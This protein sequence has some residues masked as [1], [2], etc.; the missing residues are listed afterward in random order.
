M[1]FGADGRALRGIE[2]GIKARAPLGFAECTSTREEPS[3]A[4]ALVHAHS[5]CQHELPFLWVRVQVNPRARLYVTR[6]PPDQLN[7]EG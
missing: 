6:L 3:L 5:S 1:F 4:C 7:P 2:E